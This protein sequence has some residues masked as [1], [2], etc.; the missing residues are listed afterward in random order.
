MKLTVEADIGGMECILNIA[1]STDEYKHVF[2][3]Y[4]KVWCTLYENKDLIDY[5]DNDVHSPSLVRVNAVISCFQ[6]FY[7]TYDVVEGDGMYIAPEDRVIR[8]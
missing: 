1:D 2:E 4:A 3:G 5:L 6:E 7:D 8:W